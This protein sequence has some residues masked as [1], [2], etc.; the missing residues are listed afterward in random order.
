MDQT[1]P[2]VLHQIFDLLEFSEVSALRA[3]AKKYANIGIEYLTHRIRFHCTAESIARAEELANHATLKNH[4]KALVMEGNLLADIG[5]EHSYA[6]HYDSA[7]HADEKPQPP[8]M[9]CTTRERRLYERN[10]AKF[11]RE[12][13]QKYETYR[14]AWRKQQTLIKTPVYSQIGRSITLALPKLEMIRLS[15]VGRCHHTLSERFIRDFAL[16][17]AMPMDQDSEHS[18]VQ[19]KHLLVP[20][21]TPLRSLRFL[22]VHVLSP[23]FF[24]STP[25]AVLAEVFRNLRTV[26]LT[27]RLSTTERA[28]IDLDSTHRCYSKLLTTHL[29]DALAA[30]TELKILTINF[31]DFGL[32]VPALNVK[33]ILGDTTWS[34]LRQ[35]DLDNIYADEE[36]LNKALQRQPS[37]DSFFSPLRSSNLERGEH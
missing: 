23:A 17:C 12:V 9:P 13:L 37:L 32:Y 35:L 1:P 5:C 14:I 26:S 8:E 31:D 11:D 22:E 33:S 29:S 16:D 6:S 7:H 30:A 27:F 19:L 28:G 4:V 18:A 20:T 34:K 24:S 36:Y 10:L 21:G 3:A 2:E 25:Q 15:T